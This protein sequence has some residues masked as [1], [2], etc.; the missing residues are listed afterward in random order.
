MF[1]Q[2]KEA[3]RVKMANNEYITII[4][5]ATNE[6]P[7]GPT[8]PQ[9]DDIA[10]VFH[11]GHEEIMEEL[12]LR[13]KHRND[14]WRS[15]YKSLLVIDHLAR[16]VHESMI[17]VIAAFVPLLKQISQSFTCNEK[18][19][20]RGLSVRERSRKLVELLTDG[21]LL[22]EERQKAEATRR[23]VAGEPI[24]MGSNDLGAPRGSTTT[25][26]GYDVYDSRPRPAAAVRNTNLK[27]EQER[28]DMM[29]AMRLQEEEER[30]AARAGETIPYLHP[31]QQQSKAA[32]ESHSIP[33]GRVKAAPKNGSSGPA[34]TREE[35]DHRL[36]VE[37]QRRM[38]A[39]EPITPTLFAQ[40]EAMFPSTTTTATA[41][42][43]NSSQTSANGRSASQPQ[44]TIDSLFDFGG[45]ATVAAQ[46]AV[47]S[48]KPSQQ[49]DVFD[50]F[51]S[52][53]PAQPQPVVETDFFD[54]FVTTRAQKAASPSRPLPASA[55][56]DPHA[57]SSNLAG[58]D[59]FA[60]TA[61]S[62]PAPSSDVSGDA[63]E[64]QMRALVSGGVTGNSQANRPTLG[65][66][67]G[68]KQ[69]AW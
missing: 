66:L 21:Q 24:S 57:T 45:S 69:P 11:N 29:L 39:G 59:L 9:M 49:A 51:Q 31:E 62:Q 25:A 60:Q 30:R 32:A 10:K 54:A 36:A 55:T 2:V 64:Q 6:D 67:T 56:S 63:L 44:S 42:Q 52:A 61:S 27:D 3:L 46:T 23:K 14:S 15:C 53:P 20:D 38:D 40:A 19:V 35:A 47:P 12:N 34:L 48:Q 41:P 7:W 13:L 18:G 65:D 28:I 17:P 22:R 5:E 8:G 43:G 26:S 68:H 33:V 4:H 58:T 50:P 16:N 37:L 1:H